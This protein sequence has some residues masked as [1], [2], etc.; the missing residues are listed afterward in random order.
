MGL[1]FRKSVTLCKGVKL[2]IGKTGVSLSAGIPGFRKTIHSSGRV[3][4]SVGIPG[5]GIYYVDTKNPVK[6]SSLPTKDQKSPT[7]AHVWQPVSNEP[8]ESVSPPTDHSADYTPSP[9]PVLNP[10]Y[11]QATEAD[12]GRTDLSLGAGAAASVSVIES[13]DGPKPAAKS[14]TPDMLVTDLFEHCD[15]PV[16][17][18]DV[19]TNPQPCDSGYDPET[20]AYLRSKA[21]DVFAGNIDVMLEVIEQVNP[22]DDLLDYLTDFVFEAD[23]ADC[24]EI[25]CT[26]VQDNLGEEKA[27]AAAS[28]IIR[29]ARDTF[30]LLPVSAVRIHVLNAPAPIIDNIYFERKLFADTI[31]ENQDLSDLLSTLC[32]LIR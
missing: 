5:T 16:N 2:N 28:V 31:F 20:W 17:W 19:L 32:R 14:A 11:P 23:N 3:T 18:I 4:T 1:R 22:Y 12:C 10:D 9:P 25:T 13:E 7:A 27:D 21:I 8:K 24:L 26:M 29:L 30:A 6:G 15:Y